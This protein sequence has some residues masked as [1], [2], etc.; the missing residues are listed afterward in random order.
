M[1]QRL[2][3]LRLIENLTIGAGTVPY[4][5]ESMNGTGSPDDQVIMIGR[6]GNLEEKKTLARR[7]V[8]MGE[9]GPVKLNGVNK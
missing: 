2:V 3:I 7:L 8:S 1:D 4:R 5:T 6:L 9:D